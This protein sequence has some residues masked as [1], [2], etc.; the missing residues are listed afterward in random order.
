M[1]RT[2]ETELAAAKELERQWQAKENHRREWIDREYREKTGHYPPTLEGRNSVGIEHNEQMMECGNP[3]YLKPD[4]RDATK[5]SLRKDESGEVVR[6][7]HGN[8]TFCGFT[9]QPMLLRENRIQLPR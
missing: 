7:E 9:P 2:R 4:R 3:G 1:R 5:F 8:P 6:D